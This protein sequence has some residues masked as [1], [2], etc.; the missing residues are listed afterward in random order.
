MI[1]GVL[2]LILIIFVL[3]GILISGG[4]MLSLMHNM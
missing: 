2:M 4:T 3:I 1:N